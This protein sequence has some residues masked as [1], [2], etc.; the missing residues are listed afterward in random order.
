[1]RENSEGRGER[2]EKGEDREM[3]SEERG[4]KGKKMEEDAMI[5]EAG[6]GDRRVRVKMN[7]GRR[8]KGKRRE[9]W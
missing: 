9:W 8:E 7:E 2:R 4:R 1:M 3:R 6:K 5:K